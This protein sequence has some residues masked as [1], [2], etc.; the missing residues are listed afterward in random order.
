M[1]RLIKS[2]GYAVSGLTYAIKTQANFRIHLVAVVIVTL[3]GCYFH[4]ALNEW[5]AIIFVI[6]LVLV[7]ELINTS[8]EVLVDLVSPDFNDK[9][10]KVKDIAAAAVLLAAFIAVVTGAIIFIPKLY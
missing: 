3:A 6:G 7:T 4:L 2:F 10:G 1:R 8:I 5:L 9:A